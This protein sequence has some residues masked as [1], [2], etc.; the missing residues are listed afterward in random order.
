MAVRREGRAVGNA[1]GQNKAA[2]PAAGEVETDLFAKTALGPNAV[3]IANDQ[4][5]DHELR[6]DRGPPHG[7]VVGGKAAAQI[8][9]I[10]EAVDRAQHVIRRDLAAATATFS[11]VSAR[12]GRSADI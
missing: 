9:Q 4:H 6:I 11:T 2:E 1:V 12:S 7:A 3:A 5:P 10:D 8:L